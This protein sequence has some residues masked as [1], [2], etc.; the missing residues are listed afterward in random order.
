[1]LGILGEWLLGSPTKLRIGT[2]NFFVYVLEKALH[3]EVT[4]WV[5]LLFTTCKSKAGC[6]GTTEKRGWVMKVKT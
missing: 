4:K 5:V 6:K 3:S 2:S 1:M